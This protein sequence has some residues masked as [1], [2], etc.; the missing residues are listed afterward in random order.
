MARR[1]ARAVQTAGQ[2]GVQT[3]LLDVS[4]ANQWQLVK[5]LDCGVSKTASNPGLLRCQLAQA[6]ALRRR[7]TCA[8]YAT[9]ARPPA[10]PTKGE[11]RQ[12]YDESGCLWRKTVYLL[13]RARRSGGP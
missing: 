3:L 11:A 13:R 4:E 1:A 9:V 7:A 12:T 8:Y 5:T 2:T 6:E 10:P